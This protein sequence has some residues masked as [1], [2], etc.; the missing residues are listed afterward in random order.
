MRT[1]HILL[2]P[3]ALLM[4]QAPAFADPN[5]DER[6]HSKKGHGYDRHEH[7]ED[8]GHGNRHKRGHDRQEY[9]E[10]YVDGNCKI[11]RKYEKN[12]EYKEERKCKEPRQSHYEPSRRGYYEQS[13]VYMPAPPAVYEDSGTV[14]RGTI[15]IP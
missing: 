15:R 14:I 12:G 13:P 7:W 10:E 8:H 6:G 11:K 4:F 3:I 5:K 1:L 2:L 9:K